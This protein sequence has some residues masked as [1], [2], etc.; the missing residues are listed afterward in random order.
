MFRMIQNEFTISFCQVFSLTSDS[1]RQNNNMLP[2]LHT[3]YWSQ[4]GQWYRKCLINAQQSEIYVKGGVMYITVSQGKA[5]T[6]PANSRILRRSCCNINAEHG[7]TWGKSVESYV[8]IAIV[9]QNFHVSS[10]PMGLSF[11][12]T[13][14]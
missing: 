1:H 7:T 4:S 2:L 10:V 9:T 11:A 5:N 14:L 3:S 13:H 12:S 6:T 8:S